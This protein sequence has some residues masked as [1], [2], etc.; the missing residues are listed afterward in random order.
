[1]RYDLTSG[2]E[3]LLSVNVGGTDNQ[4]Q[5]YK[6]DVAIMNSNNDTFRIANV[7]LSD[8]GLYH[9]EITNPGAADRTYRTFGFFSVA[10][11]TLESIADTVRVR[12]FDR[13]SDS[14]ALV[15]LYRSTDGPNWRR[16]WNLEEPINTWYGVTVSR[17][18]VIEIQ[19]SSNNLVGTI[20]SEL[21]NLMLLTSLN[22]AYNEL[23]GPIPSEFGDLNELTELI[24]TSNNLN[25]SIPNELGNLI[26]LQ[27]LRLD[28]NQLS[29]PIPS[30]LGNLIQLT[31]LVLFSNELSGSIPSEL[32][33]LIQ[34]T[35]LWLDNN[36]LSGPIPSELG[37][38]S[39]LRHL[40]LFNNQL[41]G[42]I[43]SELGMLSKL[44]ELDLSDNQ[45]SGP[46]PSELGMLSKLRDLYLSDNQLS[47]PI[48]S[49]LGNLIQLIELYLSNN[50][51]TELPD[52]SHIVTLGLAFG[53]RFEVQNNYLDFG[54]ILP[55]IDRLTTYAPQRP[56]REG[57][58][59]DLTSGEEL[60]LSVNVG[61]TDNQYQWYKDDVAIMNSNNDTFRIAN[62]ALSD[63]GLYHC[64]IT[65][66]GAA[67]RTYR[68]F[69]FFSVAGLTL[70]SIADTVRIRGF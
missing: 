6:D 65:N 67:D 38:L 57:V 64:E 49:E 21:G 55:N 46:I 41:S 4:Y 25:G 70:E 50:F 24:L 10:G 68:T 48:P 15:A 36:Q 5:W 8:G 9:C 30:E 62:V 45:L 44:R 18:R 52:L 17:N 39:E 11:L 13:N 12:G 29:G 60:L 56:V 3:L 59:Y 66:P 16:K 63:G 28:R 33:N 7:A 32:G 14:L 2:D 58:R 69:G 27:S 61:G 40:E 51:F 31:F 23:S 34:L 19:L 1:M 43:P 53:A 20:P 42:P 22:L 26:Q 35:I 47:G 54:D 37:M